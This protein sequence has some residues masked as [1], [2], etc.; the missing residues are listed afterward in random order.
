MKSLVHGALCTLLAGAAC[1]ATLEKLSVEEMSRKAT[2]I[3][4]GRVTECVGEA[5]RS[6]I[7][8]ACTLSA[9]ETWKGSA[10]ASVRFL[11]PGGRAN[12][13]TQTFTGTPAMTRGSEYVLFLWAGRSG[14]HQLIGL[15]QGVF[16]VTPAGSGGMKAYR[17]AATERMLDKN[18]KEIA[19]EALELTVTA[20]RRL[21]DNALRG[22]SQ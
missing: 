20:L 14:A 18:G 5:G 15:S 22:A 7:Y 21:V 6:V 10:S 11:I 17:A 12:G 3:V 8:T 4:R 2:L 16:D 1:A 19:D 13:L 9:S